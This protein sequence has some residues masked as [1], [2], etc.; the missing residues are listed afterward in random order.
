MIRVLVV[1][2]DPTILR[3]VV[4]MLQKDHL[5]VT[6]TDGYGALYRILGG[7]DYDVILTDVGMPAMSGIVLFQRVVA[8]RPELAR[9]FVF[10]TGG[11]GTAREE[12]FLANART[13]TKPFDGALLKSVIYVIGT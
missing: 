8:M 6:A 10:M 2:D 4:R 7:S 9:R 11:G 3:A 12:A 5:V 1:D 13:I